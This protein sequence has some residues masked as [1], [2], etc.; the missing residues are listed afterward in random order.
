MRIDANFADMD[1]TTFLVETDGYIPPAEQVRRLT[2]AGDRLRD[3]LQKTYSGWARNPD[4][5]NPDADLLLA[6]PRSYDIWDAQREITLKFRDKSPTPKV[7]KD[8]K[9]AT[10]SDLANDALEET[11]EEAT[12]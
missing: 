7:L 4:L 5:D 2:A 1:Y 10:S 9:P 3:Y 8:E 12:K 6:K 11:P